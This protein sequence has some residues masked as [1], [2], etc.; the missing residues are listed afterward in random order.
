MYNRKEPAYQGKATRDDG[1]IKPHLC[2]TLTTMLPPAL[3]GLAASGA[4]PRGSGTRP[5]S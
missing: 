2:I 4:N 1:L 3:A 5:H